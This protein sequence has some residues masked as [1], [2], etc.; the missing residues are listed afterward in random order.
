M[1]TIDNYNSEIKL[2]RTNCFENDVILIDGQ[3]RSG[4]NLIAVLL[5]S[6]ERVEKM[7]LDSQ[8]DYIPRYFATG[9]MSHDAAVTSLR[10]EFDE[11]LYYNMISR[12]VNFRYQ[13]YS[14][15]MKQAK[16]FIYFKRLFM[17]AD[18]EAVERIYNEKPIFQDMTHDGIHI[19]QLYFDAL[20]D[21]LKF[22]HIF[23]D[24]VQ[25]IYEQNRRGFGTRIGEDPRELQLTYNWDGHKIPLMALG[26]EQEFI[27]GNPLERLVLMV[28]A[29]FRRNVNGYLSVEDNYKKNVF[30]IEFEDFVVNPYDY[31]N[32]LESFIGSNF[33]RK[34]KKILKRERCPRP[35]SD[36]KREERLADIKKNISMKYC[37]LLDELIHDYD[38]KP[39]FNWKKN[40]K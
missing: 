30:F 16:R 18:D 24:P 9:K 25:N 12:D 37:E 3:G 23:R 27:E 2:E 6:M 31:M 10:T 11:K 38:Q 20:K 5:S 32:D 21:R 36:S 1:K 35:E 13:D 34:T 33:T 40:I 29:M 28:D 8:L 19:L 22:I 4:K 15:V 39:W 26:F 7:R 14:G 17:S